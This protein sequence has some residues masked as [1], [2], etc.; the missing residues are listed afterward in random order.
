MNTALGNQ[1]KVAEQVKNLIVREMQ[2]L[3]IQKMRFKNNEESRE[4]N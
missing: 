4:Q 1:A 2:V 3:K